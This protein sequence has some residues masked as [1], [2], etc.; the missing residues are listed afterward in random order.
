[1][2]WKV[3]LRNFVLWGSL[4]TCSSYGS[5]GVITPDLESAGVNDGAVGLG[6]TSLNEGIF[7]PLGPPT[8]IPTLSGAPIGPLPLPPSISQTPTPELLS[9]TFSSFTLSTPTF[10]ESTPRTVPEPSSFLLASLGL[11]G[12]VSAKWAAA[13]R[14]VAR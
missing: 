4:A 8:F 13:R 5:A 12:V 7:A 14:T 9:F 2:L 11:L 1:M 10:P 6:S 3:K